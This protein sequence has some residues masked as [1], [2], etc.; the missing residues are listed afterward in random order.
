LT[1]IDTAR[2]LANNM[3]DAVLQCSAKADKNISAC[4]LCVLDL[5]CGCGIS[6]AF[7]FIPPQVTRCVTPQSDLTILHVTNDNLPIIQQFFSP[8]R[9]GQMLGRTL[10]QAPLRVEIPAFKTFASKHDAILA[11]DTKRRFSLQKLANVAISDEITFHSLA[12]KLQSRFEKEEDDTAAVVDLDD[13]HWFHY[14][15][16]ITAGLVIILIACVFILCL[17]LHLLSAIIMS[18]RV[19]T[20]AAS[21]TYPSILS[22]FSTANPTQTTQSTITPSGLDSNEILQYIC[23]AL[24]I[25]SLLYL[26]YRNMYSLNLKHWTFD[27]LFPHWRCIH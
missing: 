26:L 20:A 11:A 6:S 8:D 2:V 12:D 9:I 7:A 23:I 21:Q 17:R 4:D 27:D 10:L 14:L 3:A 16:V 1:I 25:V 19:P 13:L 22:F 18:S 24:F 5:P 15:I